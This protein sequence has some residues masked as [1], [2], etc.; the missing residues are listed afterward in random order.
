MVDPRKL[1]RP[2]SC[3]WRDFVH[4]LRVGVIMA[5]LIVLIGIAT[6]AGA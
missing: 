5:G 2:P 4:R 1:Q 3:P 6:H